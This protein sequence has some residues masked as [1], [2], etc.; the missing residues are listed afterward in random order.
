MLQCNTYLK[1]KKFVILNYVFNTFFVRISYS[2]NRALI[3][4]NLFVK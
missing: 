2:V 4:D 3:L 1:H